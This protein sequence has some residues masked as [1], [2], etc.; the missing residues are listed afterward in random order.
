MEQGRKVA[1]GDHLVDIADLSV[2]W[3][4]ADFYEDEITSLAKGQKVR[5]T[6]KSQPNRI[7]EGA[8]S[9]VDPFVGRES[10][11]T[12]VRIDIANADFELRPGMYVN[13]ELDIDQGEGLT[14]PVGAVATHRLSVRSS[15]SARAEG[16]YGLPRFVKL[17]RKYG[18]LCEV[19]D[20][21]EEGERVVSS[22][23][24]LIDAESKVQGAV[25]SFEPPAG[26]ETK[27]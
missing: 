15:L 18:D 26:Q 23:N 12:R 16:R 3:V 21:L 13:I 20:G 9:L 11:T 24:F 17:G 22:G 8:V 7:F 5:L 6:A 2:V 4:W 27:P 1:V 14:I 10:R 25:K 19:L